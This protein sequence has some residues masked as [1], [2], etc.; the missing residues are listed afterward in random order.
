[1]S[2]FLQRIA[3]TVAPASAG[4]QPRLRPMLGSVFAPTAPLAH[5]EAPATTEYAVAA[6]ETSALSP[7]DAP[8]GRANTVAYR[9]TPP[10]GDSSVPHPFTPIFPA[11]SH[12]TDPPGPDLL[13]NVHRTPPV[14]DLPLLPDQHAVTAESPDPLSHPALTDQVA[15]D[16]PDAPDGHLLPPV[17]ATQRP[18]APPAATPVPAPR[19][20]PIRRAPAG[21]QPQAHQQPDEIHI[22][23]GR[24]EVAAIAPPPPRPAPVRKALSLDEYLRRGNGRQG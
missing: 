19:A 9:Q 10:I 16:R 14:R 20:A 5:F 2:N 18:E 17:P 13:P 15:R 23:I 22:H 11:A 3:A 6:R 1:V 8:T 21:G 7:H 24:I 12:R 4:A